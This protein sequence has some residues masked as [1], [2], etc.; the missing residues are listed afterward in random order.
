MK[1]ITEKEKMNLLIENF[2]ADEALIYMYNTSLRK[3]L[4]FLNK[5]SNQDMLCIISLGCSFMKGN[6]YWREPLLTILYNEN[7]HFFC[8]ED[9]KNNFFLSS[10]GGIVLIEG[11]RDDIINHFGN[12]PDVLF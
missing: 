2:K 4:L 1:I 12:V 9:K 3:L 10:T 11:N 7:E 5:K 6:F 8:L